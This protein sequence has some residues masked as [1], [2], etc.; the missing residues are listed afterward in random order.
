MAVNHQMMVYFITLDDDDDH[1]DDNFS[2]KW[3]KNIITTSIL[4][5]L[6]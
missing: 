2:E 6:N 3:R 1:S 5:D 4:I